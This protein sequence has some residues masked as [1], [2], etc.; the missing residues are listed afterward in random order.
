MSTLGIRFVTSLWKMQ[1]AQF[2]CVSTKSASGKW[3]DHFFTR[4]EFRD[5]PDFLEDHEGEDIYFCPHG[6]A[7][8]SRTKDE[9]VKPM[10]L[11]ADL[12][13][14][15]PA[16]LGKLKPTLAWESSPGRFA[17]IWVIDRKMTDELNKRLTYQI[18]ADKGGWDL[19]QVLRF[20]GTKNYKYK[21]RPTVRLLWTDGP[22]YEWGEI[23]RRVADLD[24]E[25]E[26]SGLTSRDIL[27]KHEKRIKPQ[28]RRAIMAPNV[29]DGTDRSTVIWKCI[30]DLIEAGLSEE[31]VVVVM[32]GTALCKS[33]Y[34]GRNMERALNQQI[35]K[36]VGEKLRT[37]KEKGSK[38]ERDE[39]EDA[40]DDENPW[41]IT[42]S[43]LSGV[44]REEVKWLWDRR[45]AIGS[46]TI[47]EGPP[48]MGKSFVTHMV[49]GCVL[50]GARIKS[51]RPTGFAP[52]K[53]KVL[54]LDLENDAATVVR[55]RLE[56][57]KF[58][59]L[60]D[61][62]VVRKVIPLDD[63][64]AIDA[65]RDVIRKYKPL[66]VVFDTLSYFLGN[67]SENSTSDMSQLFE[68]VALIAKQNQVAVVLLRH[69][70][71]GYGDGVSA[72]DKGAGSV[73]IG[74]TA[75][76]VLSVSRTG[77]PDLEED[78]WRVVSV[79]K[80]NVGSPAKSLLFRITEGKKG[81]AQFE[82]GEVYDST[83]DEI[84]TRLSRSPTKK[85]EKERAEASAKAGAD[86]A[87]VEAER[88]LRRRLAGGRIINGDRLRGWAETK[89]VDAG[90]LKQVAD[91][92]GVRIN[93]RD[94]WKLKE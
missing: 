59:N 58:E 74:G 15:D 38:A 7:R 9:A 3:T 81:E 23:D 33:K 86:D 54:M 73:A 24:E 76:A 26:E 55:P 52:R 75:R 72:T 88:L 25:D 80:V 20:P 77:D 94:E 44:K 39:E 32:S 34:E 28:T 85:G 46:L 30:K 90:T 10:L 43:P 37:V 66:L 11:W 83:S 68:R 18:G 48:G 79:A 47:L 35:A 87:R 2:Y 19:T 60:D 31:E 8:R 51:D 42:T 49:A 21:S 61:I 89:G 53:G 14:A 12:D 41:H 22:E 62:A 5:L 27:K 4:D 36:A 45:I 64:D 56:D 16:K 84:V 91:S 57:N 92:I 6:F 40:D 93:S 78:G 70:R 29:L 17:A 71:K 82:W 13:E 50:D 63:D 69:W 67:A 1:K 65:L